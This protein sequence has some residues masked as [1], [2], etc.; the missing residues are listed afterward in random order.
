M[1]YSDLF[2]RVQYINKDDDEFVE[3]V[4]PSISAQLL[5]AQQV[6][7]EGAL[8]AADTITAD[9]D[10]CEEDVATLKARTI[11]VLCEI[12]NKTVTIPV[13]AWAENTTALRIE[14][15]LTDEAIR[16]DTDVDLILNDVQ[17]GHFAIDAFDPQ[18]GSIML[19]TTQSFP[20]EPLIFQMIVREVRALGQS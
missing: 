12:A 20:D 14:A 15:T 7:I 19:Y 16:S 4:S 5:N 3:G 9:L 13:S 17:K 6:G 1:A 18:D 11:G 2:K 10:V 8:A